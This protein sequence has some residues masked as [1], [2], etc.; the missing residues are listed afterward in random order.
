MSSRQTNQKSL[1]AADLNEIGQASTPAIARDEQR[2]RTLST[3]GSL[4][5]RALGLAIGSLLLA[6]CFSLLLIVGRVFCSFDCVEISCWWFVPSA[7]ITY[8]W[9]RDISLRAEAN[10]I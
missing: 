8:S 9:S 3:D 7:S 5:R 2:K 6:G 10:T 1:A 4:T